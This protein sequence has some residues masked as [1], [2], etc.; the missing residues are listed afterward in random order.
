MTS[1][2]D[3]ESLPPLPYLI[4][5]IHGCYDEYLELE[6]RIQ[7][8]A[9]QQ[10]RMPLIVSVGDLIDRGPDS[11]GV[12]AHFFKGQQKGTHEA[13]LGNHE[14]MMLQVLHCLAPWNFE[15]PGCQWPM[16]LWTLEELHGRGEGMAR[17]LPWEDYLVT[18]K[19]LWIAQG[20]Y[21]TLTSY[22]MDP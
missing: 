13:V 7:Q 6:S 20:G 16:R 19:A 11:A 10:G 12:V 3:A 2:S 21:Q 18:M 5:D 4:G 1:L 15:P 9:R 14:V 8:H 17:Y 22:G